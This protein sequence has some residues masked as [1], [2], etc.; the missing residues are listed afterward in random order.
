M[1]A[2]QSPQP[3][4]TLLINPLLANTGGCHAPGGVKAAPTHPERAGVCAH[5]PYVGLRAGASASARFFGG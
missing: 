1:T 3:A 2:H 5:P 4:A